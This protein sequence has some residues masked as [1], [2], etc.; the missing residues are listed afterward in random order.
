MRPLIPI[1]LVALH[2]NGVTDMRSGLDH[3]RFR[4]L[5]F[6]CGHLFSMSWVPTPIVNKNE[7]AWRSHGKVTHIISRLSTSAIFLQR[8]SHSDVKKSLNSQNPR[9]HQSVQRSRHRIQHTHEHPI[10]F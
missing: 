6:G 9:V 7:Q 5:D 10:Y 4:S 1:N 3:R 2:Q 8:F